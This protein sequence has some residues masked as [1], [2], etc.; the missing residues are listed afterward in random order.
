MLTGRPS[1]DWAVIGA[2]HL[3]FGGSAG[4][5]CGDGCGDAP[6]GL[7]VQAMTDAQLGIK[8]AAARSHPRVL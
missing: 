7:P 1:R 6:A 2:G 4:D 3:T 8:S 5:G